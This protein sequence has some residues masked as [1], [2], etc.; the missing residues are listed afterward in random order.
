MLV[1]SEI[2]T[3]VGE[4]Q[5]D[6]LFAMSITKDPK[7]KNLVD[8][9]DILKQNLDLYNTKGLFP[10]RATGRI[11]VKWGGET[12]NVSGVD[13]STKQGSLTFRADE[14]RKIRKF[15]RQLK[16]LTGDESSHA[17]YPKA[18][19]MF[20]LD[21]Y[22]LGVDKT[23]ITDAVTL[24]NVLALKVGELS[25]DKEGSGIATFTVDICWDRALD[26]ESVIGNK[27]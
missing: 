19:A 7:R 3:S 14:K 27:I 9:Y 15:W 4:W 5:R 23:T 12:F 6:Y 16:E 2:G 1:A 13:E 24:K 25:P 8:D 10:D 21:V 11:E 26:N 20:D 22:M 18:E 17:A